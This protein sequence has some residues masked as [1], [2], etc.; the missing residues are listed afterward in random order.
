MS[1]RFTKLNRT[2]LGT[3]RFLKPETPLYIVAIAV[4]AA[5]IFLVIVIIWSTFQEGLPSLQT[6]FS[7]SLK[8]FK[9]VFSS[10][11]LSKTALNTLVLSVGTTLVTILFAV[12]MAWLIHRTTI[13]FK[14]F[15]VT[16]IL[17]HSLLPGFVRV[18]GWI[19]LLSPEIGI[20]N[21][22]IRSIIQ[23]IQT[24]PLNPYNIS[25]MTFLQGVSLTPLMF[26]MLG[27]AFMAV[28]PSLEEAAETSGLNRFQVFCRISLPLLKPAIMAGS[29]FV[30]VTAVSMFEIPALLGTSNQIFVLST[31]MYDAVQP[32]VGL[33]N[34]GIAGVYGMIILIPTLIALYYYQK[35]LKVRHRYTTVTGK[36]YRPKLM[37]LGFW[38]KWGGFSFIVFYFLI[39]LVLPYLA[40]IW[41]SLLPVIQLPSVEALGKISLNAYA[42]AIDILLSQGAVG[43]TLKLIFSVALFGMLIGLIIS[44]VVLRTRMPGRF[45]LD[46]IAMLPH[47]VPGIAL[48]FS[49]AFISIIFARSIPLHGTLA[50]IIIVNTIR[51]IP[52]TT[53]TINSSL[54]QIHPELEEAVLTS[55]ASKVIALRKIIMP[56]ITSSLLYSFIWTLL[57]TYRE[58]STALFLISPDNMVLSTV[59]WTQWY[60][61]S[62]YNASAA[63]SVIM[64]GTMA[65]FILIVM[66][67]LPQ[68]WKSIQH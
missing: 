67:S 66:K 48:A 24:G 25:F 36:G 19:M 21:Q 61:S 12:P 64:V 63:I 57:Q 8:N 45:A 15:F 5:I 38:W 34:Y 50:A 9:E 56:L 60:G 49:M 52:F 22:A 4:A 35:M 40:L 17:L 41:T 10:P 23:S 14:Q 16:L 29:I 62:N 27:G 30:F 54:I 28:D 53:R 1:Q 32:S 39:D 65:I 2:L 3:F 26:L 11:I 43:N 58:V 20:V 55:G 13:P 7:F 59:I 37:K 18:M 51:S 31:V 42:S 68:V 6:I 47:A 46:S 33:P 44:W